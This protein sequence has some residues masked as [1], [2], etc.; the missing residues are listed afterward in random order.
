MSKNK[1]HHL[2]CP[3]CEYEC[4]IEPINDKDP[5]EHCPMCSAVVSMES[6][7]EDDWE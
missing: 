1:I 2:V 5:P 4:Y 6:D 3:V 7:D